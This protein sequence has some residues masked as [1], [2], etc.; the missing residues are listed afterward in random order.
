MADRH[1]SRAV[2]LVALVL[3]LVGV[4]WP[5]LA[6]AYCR[7]TSC[8][9]ALDGT[10]CKLDHEGCATLGEPLFWP[11][12]CVS[13]AVPALA[14]LGQ[15][16]AE[17]LAQAARLAF[18]RWLSVDCG[19]APPSIHALDLGFVECRRHAFD[20]VGGN[21]NV[22]TYRADSWP[23]TDRSDAIALT[24][25]SFNLQTGEIY[26][27][28][29]ELNALARRFGDAPDAV[30]LPS[31]LAHEVGHFLGLSHTLNPDSVMFGSYRERTAPP[32]L[33]ADDIAGI[34]AIYPPDRRASSDDCAPFHGLST[35]CEAPAPTATPL[36][37]KETKDASRVESP[38]P[39]TGCN[40]AGAPAANANA[41]LWLA[42]AWMLR[43]RRRLTLVG[44]PLRNL[45]KRTS[46]SVAEASSRVA[47]REPAR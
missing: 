15:P 19:G 2:A 1:R 9:A 37:T 17:E 23:Y 12:R 40:Q 43:H 7:T 4:G 30:D 31:L 13:F 16:P 42:V 22:V 35:S 8:E 29:I 28:D 21:A 3:P 24:S 18:E 47:A 10:D 20:P 44:D 34:C 26:D 32:F 5:S 25:V 38:A 27:A 33:S 6:H 39:A 45:E 14:P 11:Q 46:A 41:A 36:P